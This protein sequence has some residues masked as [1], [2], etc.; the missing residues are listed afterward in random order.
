MNVLLIDDDPD[1]AD[2]VMLSFE[3]RWPNSRITV[4]TSGESGLLQLESENPQVVILDVVLPGMDGYAVLSAIRAVSDVPVIML[5]V[6]GS[7]EDMAGALD[8]GADDYVTKPFSPLVLLSRVQAVLRRSLQTR[9]HIANN[10]DIVMAAQARRVTIG[11]ERVDLSPMEFDL[12]F[13]LMN[14]RG[15]MVKP[16]DLLSTVWG[17]RFVWAKDSLDLQID[18]LRQKL[19]DNRANPRIITGG[20]DGGYTFMEPS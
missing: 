17:P 12:L 8:M 13:E 14:H 11:G 20:R 4:S 16:E 5:T 7:D 18:R 9:K 1:I 3:M 15:K 10:S 6:R 2:V 19:G